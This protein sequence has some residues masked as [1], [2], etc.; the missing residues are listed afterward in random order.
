MCIYHRGYVQIVY[1]H[2]CMNLKYTC[3]NECTYDKSIRAHIFLKVYNHTLRLQKLC[4]PKI[5]SKS[6]IILL[7][8]IC[9]VSWVSNTI[10]LQDTHNI[11][12]VHEAE[13]MTHVRSYSI[14]SILKWS[15]IHEQVALGVVGVLD[16]QVIFLYRGTLI[17]FQILTKVSLKHF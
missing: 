17:C 13:K 12:V 5:L 1:I 14:D 15:C 9:S 16:G 11:S 3:H 4:K 8:A 7:N 10:N 6:T 2:V